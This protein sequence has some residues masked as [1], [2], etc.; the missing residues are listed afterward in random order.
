[1]NSNIDAMVNLIEAV[2]EAPTEPKRKVKLVDMYG[3]WIIVGL[4][5][6]GKILRM[7]VGEAYTAFMEAI[8]PAKEKPMVDTRRYFASSKRRMGLN[9][10]GNYTD[11]PIMIMSERANIE[12]EELVKDRY[13][14]E[15]FTMMGTRDEIMAFAKNINNKAFDEAKD[16]DYYRKLKITQFVDKFIES[17][18]VMQHVFRHWL[19]T[20]VL[21]GTITSIDGYILAD[22]K[23]E[24]YPGIPA[25]LIAKNCDVSDFLYKYYDSYQLAYKLKLTKEYYYSVEHFAKML[26]TNIM[27]HQMGLSEVNHVSELFFEINGLIRNHDSY[28]GLNSKEYTLVS[29]ESNIK[30]KE[31]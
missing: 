18:P 20:Q 23:G 25:K 6:F 28:S 21:N 27:Q 11:L 7:P 17:T 31:A 15:P 9:G 8:W 22:I 26:M 5:K 14:T 13:K 1:M 4:A 19:Q 24:S 10:Y 12:I 29:G 30:Y 16:F 3:V 2:N